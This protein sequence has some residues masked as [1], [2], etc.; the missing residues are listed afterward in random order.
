MNTE[1]YTP[2]NRPTFE[3]TNNSDLRNKR[4]FNTTAIPQHFKSTHLSS[5][6]AHFSWYSTTLLSLRSYFSLHIHNAQ[7]H[8]DLEGAKSAVPQIQ[9]LYSR[10]SFSSLQGF[11]LQP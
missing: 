6:E 10:P 5:T 8:V 2:F 1:V 3:F 9:T 11:S 7:H 4:F